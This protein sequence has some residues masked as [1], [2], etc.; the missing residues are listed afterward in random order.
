MN[1]FRSLR[2]YEVF[3]YTLPQQ[4]GGIV[5]STLIVAQRGSQLAELTGEIALPA[6]H[7]LVVYERLTW[8]AG[9]LFTEGYS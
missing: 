9:P 7:R 2:D 8:D 3:V 6:G 4:F 1:A 5:Y